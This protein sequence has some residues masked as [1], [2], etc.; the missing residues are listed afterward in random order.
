[1]TFSF[2]LKENLGFR[3]GSVSLPHHKKLKEIAS[4]YSFMITEMA[5]RE[6]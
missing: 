5:V 1:M 4:F 2:Y 3:V 6:S